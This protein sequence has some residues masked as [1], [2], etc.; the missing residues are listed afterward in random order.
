MLVFSGEIYTIRPYILMVIPMNA[1]G[2]ALVTGASSG[3]G[4]AFARVLAETG[5]S[6]VL[7]A[8]S[9]DAL[10]QLAEGLAEQYGVTVTVFA[11]D[12]TER[13]VI[14]DMLLELDR[15]DIRIDILINN[16]GI[17]SYGLF[18][19]ESSEREEEM[20]ALNIGALT[21]LT[22]TF[23]PRM[24]E[25]GEGHIVEVASVA[26][27][28]PGPMMAVYS[29]TKA[30]VLSLT[31][32][33]AS[34]IRGTGVTI[35]ALCPGPT[36]SGFSEAAG[37]TRS[38]LFHERRL[39]SAESVARYGYAAMMAG[40]TVAVH[41]WANRLLVFAVRLLPRGAVTRLVRYAQERRQ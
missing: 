11:R 4:E 10:A 34:E 19:K 27:C 36:Q 26:G 31:E 22:R 39:P 32:A 3:I 37:A 13:E 14:S 38:R 17:G 18:A 9:E 12:L 25:R 33:I 5:Y 2:T 23:L 1:K 7:V 20:I 29:A 15:D 41:G 6:L 28:C 8:R 40:Q 30:Y 35:T 24:I 16:A 21:L